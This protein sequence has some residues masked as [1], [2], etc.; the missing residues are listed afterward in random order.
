MDSDEHFVGINSIVGAVVEVQE[1]SGITGDLAQHPGWERSR[2]KDGA[3][4]S[5][6]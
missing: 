4:N 1:H 5:L 3:G 6:Y 2:H